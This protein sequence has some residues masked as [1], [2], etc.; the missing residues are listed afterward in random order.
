VPANLFYNH[1]YCASDSWFVGLDQVG[2]HSNE[3]F[4]PTLEGARITAV[5]LFKAMCPLLADPKACTGA[6]SF[7]TDES[8]PPGTGG[9]AGDGDVNRRPGTEVAPQDHPEQR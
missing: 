3:A 5:L 9:Q 2:T 1:S 6:P 8:G 4:H 7:V